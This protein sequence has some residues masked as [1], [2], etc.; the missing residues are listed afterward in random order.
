MTVSTKR[1]NITVTKTYKTDEIPTT[2]NA[3]HEWIND[4]LTLASRAGCLEEPRVNFYT[5]YD[6]LVEAEVSFLSIS[7]ERRETDAELESRI[8]KNKKAKEQKIDEKRQLEK[9]EREQYEKLKKKYE[10]TTS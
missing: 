2:L 3:L 5:Q 6:N 7:Y 8:F 1:K 10:S 4:E 9:K